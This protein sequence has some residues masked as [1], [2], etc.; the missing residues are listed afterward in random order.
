MANDSHLTARRMN[1]PAVDAWSRLAG[2][3]PRS[4]S[5]LGLSAAYVALYLL[6]DRISSLEVLHGLDVTPWQPEPGLSV[7]LLLVAGLDY[8]P[9]VVVAALLSSQLLPDVP[10][11][12][13]TALAAA[14]VIGA[15]YTAAA[16]A[17]RYVFGID[18]RLHRSRDIV[19]LIVATTLAAG[20]A[21]G[22]AVALYTAAGLFS[23][24]D[25]AVVAFGLWIG[26]A[27]GSI[28][29]APLLLVLIDEPP[30]FRAF[31]KH[32]LRLAT[33][34]VV[35]QWAC[36]AGALALLFGFSE[37]RTELFYL[38]FL[39]LVW[40]AA[41]RGLPGA[42]WAVLTIQVGLLVVLEIA[43][44]SMATIRTFQLLMFAVATTGLMLGAFVSERHR[45]ARALADSRGHLATILNTARD[46]VLTV[47]PKGRIA[48]V[49][50][51]VERLF[52]RPASA[53]L[54]RNI[55]ELIDMPLL[56]PNPSS[57]AT[58]AATHHEVRAWQADGAPFPIELTIGRFGAPGNEHGTLV[59]RDIT[60]RRDAE[61]RARAHESELANASRLMF[62]DEMASAVAHELNQPLTAIA[63]YGRGCLRLLRQSD[64]DVLKE[65][66]RELVQQAERAADVIARLRDFVRTG[67]LQRKAV[68]VRTLVDR[69]LALFR[70]EAEQNGM[71]LRSR[72]PSDLPPV[73]VDRIHME[74]VILNLVRNAMDAMATAGVST[75]AV[76]LRAR[77]TRPDRVEI[78]IADTGPGVPEEVVARLFHPFVTTKAGGMGLGLTISHSMVE[79]HGGQLRL[80]HNSTSG[81]AFAFDLPIA[82][83]Q[84][85]KD[86]G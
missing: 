78:S 21:T 42:T 13:P 74:Q 55:R 65:G 37:H 84:E 82:R 70:A 80:A 47:D 57:A 4:W 36:I 39:P 53:L 14:L 40:I 73:L 24:D 63:A 34:E 69:T 81:A 7:A 2:L 75:K 33:L 79:A 26:N 44:G 6:L 11:P 85:A 38:L 68:D 59:I 19:A 83:S 66:L 72:V 45:V 9:V 71:E 50:P 5:A 22:G 8:A 29:L 20:V 62:A 15:A 58:E 16:A 52:G 41:R 67:S 31:L 77:Q 3:Q 64:A 18:P 35:V 1:G 76:T 28:V 51:S 54:G 60:A 48:S 86:V 56:P 43:G 23:A 10:V 17:L 27:I 12:L 49:N 30:K 25:F 46:G 61:T 32:P